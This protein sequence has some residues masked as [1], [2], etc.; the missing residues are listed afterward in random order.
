MKAYFTQNI[1]ERTTGAVLFL[2]ASVLQGAAH[3][4]V[5]AEERLG[6]RRRRGSSE[7]RPRRVHFLNKGNA[8]NGSTN[9]MYRVNDE[10]NR[11]CAYTQ[12]LFSPFS[13]KLALRNWYT[14]ACH[15]L[16]QVCLQAKL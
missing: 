13:M 11:R 15:A 4:S 8:A 9:S 1:T 12:C 6:R 10:Q 14:I 5:G 2:R 16:R 3:R 7:S